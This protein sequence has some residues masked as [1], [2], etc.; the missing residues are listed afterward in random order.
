MS[1]YSLFEFCVDKAAVK[2]RKKIRISPRI[3]IVLSIGPNYQRTISIIPNGHYAR[4]GS[5]TQSPG[6]TQ[7]SSF[8]EHSAQK[9]ELHM[10]WVRERAMQMQ[11]LPKSLQWRCG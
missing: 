10:Q 1:T 4:L 3:I 5:H 6:A 8:Y 2:K 11:E 7:S 9:E